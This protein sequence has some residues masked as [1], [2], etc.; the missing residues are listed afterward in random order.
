[1]TVTLTFNFAFDVEGTPYGLSFSLEAF[2][3]CVLSILEIQTGTFSFTFMDDEGI[4]V[5]HEK[6]LGIKEPT[7]IVTYSL[8][9]ESYDV[10]IYVGVDTVFRHASVFGNTYEDE[11]KMVIV[12]GLLHV[13]GY[14]D[15][16]QVARAEMFA[17]QD[18]VLAQ[19]E[20]VLNS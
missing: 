19:V 3:R 4:S 20:S 2:T 14:D 18:R 13:M 15:A 6:H 16:T 12:H 5:I 11:M 9:D 17:E 7:D 1:M 10:D 8:G